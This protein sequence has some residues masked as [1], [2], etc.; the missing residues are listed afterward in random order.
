MI[1]QPLFGRARPCNCERTGVQQC[2]QPMHRRVLSFATPPTYRRVVVYN[3]REKDNTPRQFFFIFANTA[4][5]FYTLA[6][7]VRARLASAAVRGWAAPSDWR[8]AA[9]KSREHST[10]MP[11]TKTTASC[12]LSVRSR[13]NE[14]GQNA[15]LFYV[16]YTNDI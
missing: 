5:L 6:V 4:R 10:S 13:L 3:Q 14:K 16:C 1:W 12:S 9:K 7:R 15:L 2:H 8:E 11:Q